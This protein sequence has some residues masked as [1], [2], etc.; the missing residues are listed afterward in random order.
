MKTSIIVGSSILL[1]L[2][3]GYAA[4]KESREFAQYVADHDCVV[5]ETKT[6]RELQMVSRYDVALKMTTTTPTWVTTTSRHYECQVDGE[7]GTSFW[8]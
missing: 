2:G 6:E 7:S 8:R 3:L 1:I 4:V 5:T